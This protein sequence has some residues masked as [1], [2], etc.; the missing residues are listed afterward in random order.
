MDWSPIA[1]GI[2]AATLLLGV[3]TLR[4]GNTRQKRQATL[5][6][7]IQAGEYR[8]QLNHAL[9][10][11]EN[12]DLRSPHGSTTGP[13]LS[14]PQAYDLAEG[15]SRARGAVREYLDYWEHVAVGVRRGVFDRRTLHELSATRVRKTY[16]RFASYIYF[17]RWNLD[18]PTA[19]IDFERL[20]RRFGAAKP[21]VAQ[22][23]QFW[24]QHANSMTDDHLRPPASA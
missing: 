16:E 5:D 17:L 7:Y 14:L 2:A 10:D 6:V 8:R 23:R 9:E 18:H 22:Y 19:Y 12:V 24:S 3:V 15:E 4:R 13:P 21:A 20:A 1:N 11:D